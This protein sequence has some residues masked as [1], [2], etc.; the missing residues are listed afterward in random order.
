MTMT[1]TMT[2]KF[3]CLK[4]SRK[5]RKIVDLFSHLSPFLRPQAVL[6]RRVCWPCL[7]ITSSAMK[8]ADSLASDGGA[9]SSASNCHISA[10]LLLGE[11]QYLWPRRTISE[12]NFRVSVTSFGVVHLNSRQAAQSILSNLLAAVQIHAPVCLHSALSTSACLFIS[13]MTSPRASIAA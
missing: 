2:M 10:I 3:S 13:A 1:M 12:S 5:P 6:V 11:W 8:T 7:V 9:L 4:F